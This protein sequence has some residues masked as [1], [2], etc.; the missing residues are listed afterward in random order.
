MKCRT[1]LHYDICRFNSIPVFGM[2][3]VA[4]QYEAH[5]L[6]GEWIENTRYKRKGKKFF[7]CSVCHYGENGDVICEVSK[8]PNFCPNCGANMQIKKEGDEK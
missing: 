6:V 2:D 7:D 3:N 1:C 5:E 8:L 4:C